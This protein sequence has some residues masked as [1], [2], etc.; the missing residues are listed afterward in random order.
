MEKKVVRNKPSAVRDNIVAILTEKKE[1]L[2]HKDF[3]N[4]FTEKWDRVT[5]YRALDKLVDEGKIHKVTGQE[6]VVQYALCSTCDSHNHKHNHNHVHFNC[7][8]CKRVTCIENVLPILELPTGFTTQEV[9]CM[10][11]GV[12]YDCNQKE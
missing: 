3:Q 7:V 9:Q 6:G 2:A 12:C 5:I 4:L 11:T 10:V 1:A 8:K